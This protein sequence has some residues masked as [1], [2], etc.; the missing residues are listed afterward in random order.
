MA[1][2][3]SLA[4][5]VRAWGSIFSKVSPLNSVVETWLVLIFSYSVVSELRGKVGW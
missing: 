1:L 3:A 5:R 4:S 2:E